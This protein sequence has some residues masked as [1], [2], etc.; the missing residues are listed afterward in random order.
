MAAEFDIPRADEYLTLLRKRLPDKTYNHVQSVAK[1]MITFHEEAGCTLEQAIT[2]GLLHDLCKAF[3]KD[4][5]IEHARALGITKYLDNHNLLHGPAAA[6]ECRQLLNIT[7]HEVLEAIEY[8]T[9]GRAGWSGVGIAL[10]IADFAE[11]LRPYPAAAVARDMLNADGVPAT[12]RFVNNQKLAR[13][14]QK[15]DLDPDTEAFA[16]WVSEN[17]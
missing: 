8:H 10:Y 7:D 13:V 3:K 14:K 6:A 4:E 9:T 16:K 15:F 5:L 1:L 17:V 2:A 12:L 11:P